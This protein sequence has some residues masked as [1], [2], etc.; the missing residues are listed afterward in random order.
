MKS[1][2]TLFVI[3]LSTSNSRPNILFDDYRDRRK[4]LKYSEIEGDVLHISKEKKR[5][6]EEK[7]RSYPLLN[8][9]YKGRVQD[10]ETQSCFTLFFVLSR[11]LKQFLWQ[12][13][14]LQRG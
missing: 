12:K 7:I 4:T 2:S 1:K 5:R 3:P 6:K 13:T 9:N 8:I 10:R 11:I 14:K